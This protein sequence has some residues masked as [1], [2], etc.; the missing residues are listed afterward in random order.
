MRDVVIIGG[1]LT[2]LAAAYELE[3]QKIPYTLIE[4]KKRLGGGIVSERRGDFVLDGGLMLHSRAGDWS[5]LDDL[6]LGD[7]LLQ[8][9][10]HQMLFKDGAQ[11]LTDAL[12]KSLTGSI[13]TRMAVSSLGVVGDCY[14]VCLENGLVLDSRAL[15]VTAPA[16]YAG[17]MLYDLNPDTAPLLMNYRY[18][19]IVRVSL[20]YKR[21]EITL[22]IEEPPDVAFAYSQWTDN[23]HRV[24]SGQILLQL[25]LRIKPDL[26]NIN[27]WLPFILKQMGLPPNP[28]V[29][30]A[31]HWPESDPLNYHDPHHREQMATLKTLLPDG[32]EL[33][34]SDYDGLALPERVQRGREAARKIAVCL[35]R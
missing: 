12:A 4:V 22:P 10:D 8:V 7:G 14:G 1:G 5:F 13:M 15:I 19:T 21:E 18:D 20:G 11:S 16:R 24:P 32:V 17:H 3:R 29:T 31:Y 25:G 26:D 2:G 9:N 33:A 6:G 23:P 28:L 34:G 30:Y 35:G 27:T